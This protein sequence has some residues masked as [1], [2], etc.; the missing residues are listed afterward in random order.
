APAP[1][2]TP[3]NL[4]PTA[5]AGF[6]LTPG[7]EPVELPVTVRNTGET[8]SEPVSAALDLPPGVRSVGAAPTFAGA[9]LVR[10]DG[11]PEQSVTCPAGSGTVTCTT[12][13]GIAPGGT[14]TF[15]FRLQADPDAQG[16][17]ITGTLSA[18]VSLSVSIQVTVDVRP[19]HDDLELLVHKWQHGFWDPRLDIRAT[20]TGGRDGHLRLVV[21]SS[22][23]VTLVALWPG[24]DRS[25]HRVVCEVPLDR[26]ETFRLP[27]W[28][29]GS[30]H[31]DGA[32]KVSATLGA[33]A[34]S[35]DL[36]L[37]LR[38]GESEGQAP[39][40]PVGLPIA[41][42]ST[43]PTTPAPTTP[44]P[45]STGTTPTTES[46]TS[47]APTTPPMTTTTVPP[48]TT[49]RST[50][51]PTTPPPTTTAPPTTRPEDPCP[52]KPPG[53]PRSPHD[54]GPDR[55]RTPS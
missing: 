33:A 53:Q 44:G 7:D 36:V 29:L 41:P 24:C 11:A 39:E 23:H 31:R 54:R 30:P 51:T 9:R 14:A 1:R 47:T 16:G 34:E 15:V 5:P 10:F 20:N 37:S 50:P 4:V 22:E 18:G 32:V 38:P 8:A 3:P 17:R 49:T 35:V 28:A 52:R 40:P 13:R 6:T 43:T 27:V 26:G 55:C 46:R 48:T 2:P 19:V 25:R 12:S 21:E 42:G 45:T